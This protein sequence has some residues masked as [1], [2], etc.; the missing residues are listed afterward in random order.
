MT[1]LFETAV[2]ADI[3]NCRLFI[4]DKWG[5]HFGG[6]GCC[7]IAKY[8][9]AYARRFAYAVLKIR[10]YEGEKKNVKNE[11]SNMLYIIFFGFY[12]YGCRLSYICGG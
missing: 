11:K 12:R 6:N 2:E 5:K 1:A 3:F 7:R 4:T 8:I 9:Y 10:C